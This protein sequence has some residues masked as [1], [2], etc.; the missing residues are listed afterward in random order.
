MIDRKE[1]E[2]LI[3]AQLQG[4]QRIDTVTKSILDLQKA[5]EGQAAAA[6]RGEGSIDDLKASMT[7][8]KQVQDA[9][10]GQADTIG[11]FQKL[12]EQ[13]QKTQERVDKARKSFEDY[14]AKLK[15]LSAVTD[16]QQQRLTKLS[17]GYDRAQGTLEKQ[18]AAYERLGTALRD[19]G[20]DTNNLAQA[21][22][23][24]R[25]AAA[26]VGTT[27]AN[28]QRAIA[29]Y[30]DDMRRAREET[31]KKAEADRDAARNQA[32]LARLQAGNDADARLGAQQRLDALKKLEQAEADRLAI[33][34]RAAQFEQA[35]RGRAGAESELAAIRDSEEFTRRFLE[36]QKQIEE[37]NKRNAGLRKTADDAEAAARQYTTL[38]RASTNLRPKVVSLAEAV[39]QIIDPANVSRKSLAE[40]E[41]QAK[42][43]AQGVAAIKGPVKDAADQ[44]KNLRDV[45]KAIASQASLID[46]FK[47]QKAALSEQRQ[48]L[49]AARF[50]VAKYA[51]AVRQGG[52]AGAAFVKPLAEAENR[53]KRA[54]A[55]LKEQIAVTLQ[56]RDA[57]QRAGIAAVNLA[58]S[59]R[60]LADV[61]R[62]STASV[63]ALAQ[64]V[65]QYGTESERASGGGKGF[66]LF[67]DE[68]RTTLSLIQRIRG[69][70]L[71]LTA[72]YVGLQGVIG[73]AA[74]ALQAYNQQQG[75]QNTLAFA[76]NT[77]ANGAEVA[78]EIE[79]LV[80]QA[81]RLGI[82]FE[83]ASK[84]Y[85]K[86][87]AAARKSGASVQESRFIFE[88]FSEVARVINLTPD[89]ING[90]FNA[91][92]QSF[93]KG[94]IQAEELRQQ[95]GERLPGAFAFA[96]EALKDT[97]PNLDKALENG[98]VGA[99]NLLV[100]AES[101][102]KAA[103][104]P[105][106]ASLV[107]LNAEQQRFNNSVLFFK[108][109]IA[110][111]GFADAYT[112]FLK[113]L[114]TFL[115][116]SDGK[117]FAQSISAAF[118]LLFDVLRGLLANLNEIKAVTATLV[119]LFGVALFGTV[120]AQASAAAAAIAGVGVALTLVQKAMLVLGAFVV[121]WNIGSYF[122][123]KFAE[124]RV[125]A[126]SLVLGFAEVWS[127]IKFG[128]MELWEDLPRLAGNA[129]KEVINSA[130]KMM[131]TLLTIFGAGARALGLTGLSDSISAAVDS[132]TLKTNQNVSSRVAE[133]R[134]QAQA[135]LDRI[136]AIGDQMI[137]DARNPPQLT[138]TRGASGSA[139][140]DSPGKRKSTITEDTSKEIEKRANEIQALNN[141][142]DG[143]EAESLK[144]QGETLSSL[145]AAVDK[146]YEPL[147]ER[148]AKLG[149]PEA[150]AFAKRL[151]VGKSALKL[152]ITRDFNDRL[153][154]E[155]EALQRKIEQADAAAGRKDKQNLDARLQ[156]VVDSYAQT[157]RDIEALR[158]RLTQAGQS[159]AP[160]D[161]AKARLDAAVQEIRLLETQKFFKEELQR[162]EQSINDVLKEREDR[163][164][165]IRNLEAAGE[166]SQQEADSRIA[167]VI[168]EAQPRIEQLAE[169]GRQFAISIRAALDPTTLD[170]F[171]AK[172]DAATTSGGRLNAQLDRQAL[173]I[174][175]GI[176]RGVDT[177]LDSVIGKLREVA[178]GTAKWSDVFKTAGQS[179]LSTIADIL[180]ELG[181]AIIKQQILNLL[182][183]IPGLPVPVA[184]SG[185]VVGRP[186]NRSRSVDSAWFANAPRYHSGGVVG[187]APDEYPAILQKNEEVL[188]KS[189]PRNVLNGGGKATGGPG[190]EG[191]RVVLVDDRAR[192]PEAMA[193][194]EGGRVV[195]Q[196]IKSNL[197][198]IRA[199]LKGA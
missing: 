177:T 35:N 168:A 136:R 111:A 124:V 113:D 37:A 34:Q 155:Q 161:E 47:K 8:L 87:A 171:I 120:A 13:V 93:S 26:D 49:S 67:R 152:E 22:I 176:G 162:R 151:E 72:A 20:V 44:F 76:F 42:T 70:I 115:Q 153:L 82:S 31:A 179:I 140:T 96:Q 188:A 41:D 147:A 141:A 165:A 110:D 185:A 160:A 106:S 89:E 154:A 103:A 5:I 33:I 102:R 125:A 57:L 75:L 104:G 142:L 32:L 117:A 150:L 92:G 199:L 163:I 197:P 66:S 183:N 137:A 29:N 7:A 23:K 1:I 91:I 9:L 112:K 90:L 157:Y 196:H 135:D 59:E 94:K 62:S 4:Q 178:Q 81:D 172:L 56:A 180:L 98:Q 191:M 143:L 80:K 86:F 159:T 39:Q 128:A 127:R 65:K 193:G 164:A 119:G 101:V 97:F 107:S 122:Y 186:S 54:A 30:A 12:A 63:T 55:A 189:D 15:G 84:S 114:T 105:L 43:L 45:Q 77:D 144:K 53:V 170:A 173:I 71:A 46:E 74:G 16:E 130:T 40:L 88:A 108:K 166:L 123:D 19:L 36:N 18:R 83:A 109:E 11:R 116:S 78:A 60:R 28:G 149:G 14:E 52:D 10:A 174:K 121:A 129:F 68:G 118:T 50:E 73:L 61:A 175:N 198:T 51:A 25:Q 184:H 48:E 58:E 21:E 192:V 27:L 187:L 156:A 169:A 24:L 95:I 69:E 181:K 146:E 38:A 85:A 3:R 6:K 79:Y 182:R 195:V 126:A 99:E 167:T 194:A 132:L 2:L 134:R 131:R 148:I 138:A 64:A 139:T 190:G 17:A 158:Q 145:L 100:I 133:I